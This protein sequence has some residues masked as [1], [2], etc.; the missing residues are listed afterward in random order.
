MRHSWHLVLGGTGQTNL[1][2]HPRNLAGDPSSLPWSG[3]WNPS[4]AAGPP[5]GSD[6]DH[7]TNCWSE[8]LLVDLI[9]LLGLLTEQAG[10]QQVKSVAFSDQEEFAFEPPG[11]AWEPRITVLAC[12]ARRE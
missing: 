1:F 6:A 8:L 9:V 12:K 3:E 10:I 7:D 5:W 2:S 4:L 11:G